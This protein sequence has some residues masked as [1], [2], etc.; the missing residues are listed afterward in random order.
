MVEV[1]VQ[2]AGQRLSDECMEFAKRGYVVAAIDYRLGWVPGDEKKPCKNFCFLGECSLMQ[3]DSCKAVYKD[4]L[5]FA[6][7]RALQDAAA[8]MRFIVHYA[9]NLNIDTNFLYIGGYSAGAIISANLCYMNQQELNLAMPEREYSAWTRNLSG[10]SFTDSYKIAGLFNNW[11]CVYD[12]I[13]IKGAGD[14][15]PMIAFHG[16]D[17]STVPF[18]KGFPL[19]CGNGAYGYYYGAVLCTKG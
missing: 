14:K 15:I 17:D 19:D 11:G 5:N 8:A 9:V 12:T 13:Y 2:V 7:Y 6:M 10:N 16:I 3:D 1:F 4:S 18:A